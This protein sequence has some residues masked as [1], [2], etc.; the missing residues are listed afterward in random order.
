MPASAIEGYNKHIQDSKEVYDVPLKSTDLSP[1]VREQPV[2][3]L[4][5]R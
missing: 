5:M 1:V 4:G 2:S 3:F